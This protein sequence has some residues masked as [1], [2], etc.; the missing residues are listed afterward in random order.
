[1]RQNI[2]GYG[3]LISHKSLKKTISDRKYVPVIVKGYKRIFNLEIKKTNDSD[4]LNLR[5][6]KNSQF[7]AVLFQ[8]NE[9]EL[10]ELMQR[11][12]PYNLEK[13]KVYDFLT[14]KKIGKAYL[15]IDYIVAIDHK[16][17]KPTKKYFILCREA[18]YHI[19]DEF[20]KMWDETTYT[21]S[22]KKI[23]NWLKENKDYNT[24]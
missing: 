5:S 10:R 12:A 9:K 21:S 20:G 17:K 19:S 11:E 2:I 8:V 18:A 6:S 22:G 4:V 24:L 15:V 1:M 13:T 23:K 3:S 14:L 16:N 7:N